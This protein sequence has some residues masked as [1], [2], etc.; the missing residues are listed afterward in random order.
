MMHIFCLGARLVCEHI[1]TSCF[2][3]AQMMRKIMYKGWSGPMWMCEH[4]SSLMVLNRQ[5]SLAC[6]VVLG[7]ALAEVG[8]CIMHDANHGAGGASARGALGATLDL[9]R[10]QGPHS[11]SLSKCRASLCG[12]GKARPL[13]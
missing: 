5:A 13:P 9:V 1:R 3:A 12:K 7:V 11:V 8:V 4:I 10:K 2:W 6:A